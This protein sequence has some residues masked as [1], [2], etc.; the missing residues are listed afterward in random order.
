MDAYSEAEYICGM[1]QPKYQRFLD[2]LGNSY[3]VCVDLYPKTL[4]E[5]YKKVTCWN[6][7]EATQESKQSDA[8]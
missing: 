8:I 7:G 5:A 4:I 2:E 1:N 3:N 6:G